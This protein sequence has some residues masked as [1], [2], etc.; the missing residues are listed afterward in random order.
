ME[1]RSFSRRRRLRKDRRFECIR[2]F[3]CES[4]C[5]LCVSVVTSS[6]LFSPQRENRYFARRRLA[7]FRSSSA[8]GITSTCGK[9][10]CRAAKNFFASPTTIR[11]AA[12]AFNCVEESSSL[13]L[14]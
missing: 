12:P 3:L 4:L 8:T 13:H 7:L 5:D 10:F 9:S 6:S 2:E 11:L 14:L 1:A